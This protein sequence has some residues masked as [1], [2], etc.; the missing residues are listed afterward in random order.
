MG[1]GSIFQTLSWTIGDA[2]TRVFSP[3]LSLVVTPFG[4]R[5]IPTCFENAL[6]LDQKMGPKWGKEAFCKIHLGTVGVLKQEFLPQFEPVVAHLA[7]RK[8]HNFESG[9]SLEPKG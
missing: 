7:H 8:P 3:F 6:F 4:P 2:Q 5:K 1:Q 9:P